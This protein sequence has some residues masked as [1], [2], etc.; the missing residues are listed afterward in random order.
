VPVVALDARLLAAGTPALRAALRDHWGDAI[1]VRVDDAPRALDGPAAEWLRRIPALTV[2]VG[3]APPA[4]AFDLVTDDPAEADGWCTS[5]ERAPHAAQAAALLLRRPAH[6]TW[7]GLVHESLVYSLLQSGPEFS[8]WRASHAAAPSDDDAPR[9]RVEVNTRTR[10]I[11][12]TRPDRHNA[13]DTRM[14]DE[15]L[16]AL[17][18]AELVSG[19]VVVRGDGSSFCSGGDLDT[20]GTFP[21]PVSSHEI[22][23]ARS[24]AWHFHG[25]SSRMVVGVHGACL[26][27]GIELP[28]FAS[29]VVATTDARFGLPELSLG[30]VPGAGGTVSITRRVGRSRLLALLLLDGT[31]PAATARSWGLVDELVVPDRLDERLDEISESRA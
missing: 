5:F 25:L 16:E 28:A 4:D 12:L 2:G 3:T 6:D 23:L 18:E 29:H 21:D 27:A 14:R 9:V 20:F 19:P 30:L 11:V 17:R 13:I 1:L 24:L 8:A 31:I 22:R 10:R 26:G 15:L 7:T